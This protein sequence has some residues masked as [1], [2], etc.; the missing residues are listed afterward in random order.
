MRVG[1]G[2]EVDVKGAA[3]RAL[4]RL[5]ECLLLGVRLAGTLVK[6]L[7]GEMALPIEHNGAD[8]GVG[9]RAK[10]RLSR[11]LEGARRPMQ[12]GA[13]VAPRGLRLSRPCNNRIKAMRFSS[14]LSSARSNSLFVANSP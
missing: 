4:A 9:A 14:L 13:A 2:L 6:A 7:A 5:G 12:V 11:Q 10:A 1:E 3:F 8:H